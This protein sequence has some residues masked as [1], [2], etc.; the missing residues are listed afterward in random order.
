MVGRATRLLLYQFFFGGVAT[1]EDV[2]N[3]DDAP[4]TSKI[5]LPASDGGPWPCGEDG[6]PAPQVSCAML[7]DMC[8]SPFA[9]VWDTPPPGLA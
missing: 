5:Q 2:W 7:S 9:E 4:I 3:P 6:C 1:T 8:E